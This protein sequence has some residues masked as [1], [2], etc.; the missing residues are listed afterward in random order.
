VEAALRRGPAGSYAIQA[1]IAA[2]HAEAPAAADTD[3]PQIASLY[4]LLVR[5]HPSPVVELNRAVAVAMAD[6]YEAGLAIIDRLLEADALPGYHWLPAARADLLR[7]LGRFGDAEA[8][9]LQARALAG[10]AADQRFLDRRI[11]EVRATLHGQ[12]G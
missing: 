1:A 7:R 4:S 5:R 3:W 9:Y 11:A 8:A 10:N 6:G 2:L 12:R